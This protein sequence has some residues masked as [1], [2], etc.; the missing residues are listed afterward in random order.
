MGGFG[1]GPPP[2]S[3]R[4]GLLDQ[5]HSGTKLKKVSDQE[6]RQSLGGG[7]RDDLLKDIRSG[8]TLK[9]VSWFCVLGLPQCTCK[10]LETNNSV[11]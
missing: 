4:A 3:G 7:G 2:S 5:I 10:K 8:K 11:L 6:K 9:S 1:G